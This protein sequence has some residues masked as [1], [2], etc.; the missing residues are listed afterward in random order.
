YG[1]WLA[2]PWTKIFLASDP[3]LFGPAAHKNLTREFRDEFTSYFVRIFTLLTWWLGAVAGVILV[4]RRGGWLDV[5]WGVIAGSVA[6]LAAGATCACLLLLGDFVPHMLWDAALRT[7][8]S[9]GAL[10]PVWIMLAAV[11]WTV[12]GAVLGLLLGL[13]GPLGRAFLVP[14]QYALA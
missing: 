4:V 6:G 12:L 2:L 3:D 11:C 5:P 13:T 7:D 1:A 9:G 8:S 10:L 14:V